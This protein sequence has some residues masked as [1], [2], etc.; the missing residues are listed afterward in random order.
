VLAPPPV[1][2]AP[3]NLDTCQPTRKYKGDAGYDLHTIEH[4]EIPPGSFVDVHTGVHIRMPDGVYGRIT[5]RSSTF[6]TWH[7]QVQEGII[8]Q[9]YT[10]ELFIGVS[11]PNGKTVIVPKGTRLAQILFHHLVIPVQ[12]EFMPI[13]A[14]QYATKDTERGSAGFGSTGK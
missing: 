9:G 14:F 7:L 6:R 11:N 8:D 1:I 13:D 10:G 4:I 3:A 12:W 5:N 2:F